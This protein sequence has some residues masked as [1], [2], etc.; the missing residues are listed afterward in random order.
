MSGS[1]QPVYLPT[2]QQH[3]D[4]TAQPEP[5]QLVHDSSLSI[6]QRLRHFLYINFVL[7]KRSFILSILRY[8]AEILLFVALNLYLVAN[9]SFT[10]ER[11]CLSTPL[12]GS[13]LSRIRRD[14]SNDSTKTFSPNSTSNTQKEIQSIVTS[15]LSL[16]NST[17][18][19]SYCLLFVS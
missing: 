15:T 7:N 18:K 17:S 13:R 16:N 8:C 4:K 1:E 3:S 14:F 11:A 5:D 10:Y 12:N 6:Y 9:K 2:T 19:S